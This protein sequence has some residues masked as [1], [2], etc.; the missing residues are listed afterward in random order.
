MTANLPTRLQLTLLRTATYSTAAH[1][2]THPRCG[3][4]TRFHFC[5][6]HNGRGTAYVKDTDD[7]LSPLKL[8]LLS[9]P[10]I[11]PSR[12]KKMAG[13]IRYLRG[14]R[15]QGSESQEQAEHRHGPR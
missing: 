1:H 6:W 11:Q 5:N 2:P 9:L 14:S 12:L 4:A 15:T 13:S 7:P 10:A 3:R 8:A